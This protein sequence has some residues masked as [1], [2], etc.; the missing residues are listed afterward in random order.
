[1]SRGSYQ[2]SL[3]DPFPATPKARKLTSGNPG[4]KNTSLRSGI[5]GAFGAGGGISDGK[6]HVEQTN[7]TSDMTKGVSVQKQIRCRARMQPKQQ[8][9]VLIVR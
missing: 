4:A 7:S 6:M 9:K 1:M 2:A 5:F 8:I 3:R